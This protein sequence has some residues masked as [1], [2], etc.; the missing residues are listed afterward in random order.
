MTPGR[1]VYPGPD[2]QLRLAPGDY[3]QDGNGHWYFRAPVDRMGCLDGHTVTEHDDGTVTVSP[4]I[5]LTHAD[6]SGNLVS[7]HGYL[8]RGM[9][10]EC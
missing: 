4:S 6:D 9:W 10:R 8:E 2:G 1:R 3:G 5:L 7:W